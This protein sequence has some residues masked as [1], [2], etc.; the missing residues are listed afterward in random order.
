[1]TNCLLQSSTR[2]HSDTEVEWVTSA[3]PPGPARLAPGQ[4]KRARPRD[5]WTK[6]GRNH[7]Q[8]DPVLES[9]FAY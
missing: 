3:P 9:C 7:Y 6:A 8:S 2:G 1:M 4:A 5:L